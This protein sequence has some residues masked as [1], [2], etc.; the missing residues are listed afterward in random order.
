[1]AETCPDC[2][3]PIWKGRYDL[4]PPEQCSAG[5]GL[6]HEE[7]ACLRL[8]YARAQA[9]ATGNATA[10]AAEQEAHERTR[11]ECTAAL[12]AL[13]AE[14]E[15]LRTA[16][17]SI[18]DLH[19]PFSRDPLTRAENAVAEAQSIARRALAQEPAQAGE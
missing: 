17:E 12:A 6:E 10:L 11:A 1:M 3:R 2:G 18:A 9:E 8:A 7:V 15:R 16:L 13:E 19:A 4:A 14:N 5:D